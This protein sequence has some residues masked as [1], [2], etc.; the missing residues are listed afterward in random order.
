MMALV[1]AGLS[2]SVLGQDRGG[3]LYSLAQA[4]RGEAGYRQAC[5]SCHGDTLEGQGQTPSLEGAEF[6]ARWNGLP[7]GEL[8]DKIQMSMPADRPGQLT[9]EQNAEI[10]AYILKANKFPSGSQEL[11]N[12]AEALKGL[13]FA[14]ASAGK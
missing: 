2:S 7:I 13:N 3:G 4:E 12:S 5:A 14:A 10:L 9:R 1:I 6:T 8:F 11:P